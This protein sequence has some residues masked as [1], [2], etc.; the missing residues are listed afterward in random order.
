MR[1]LVRQFGVTMIVIRKD[2][3]LARALTA[4]RRSSRS[5]F[6]RNRA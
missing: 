1:E 4:A 6:V 2:F 3:G 5:Y